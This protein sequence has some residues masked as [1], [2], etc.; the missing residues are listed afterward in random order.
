VE[1]DITTAAYAGSTSRLEFLAN[2]TYLAPEDY[3]LAFAAVA[4]LEERTS[5]EAVT[6]YY[7]RIGAGLCWQEAFEETFRISAG[8]FYDLFDSP[9]FPDE[10]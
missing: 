5:P 3:S 4:R 2:A 6:L 8:D 9:R 10:P 1:H 7:K